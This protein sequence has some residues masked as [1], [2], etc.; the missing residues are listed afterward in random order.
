M[1]S[2]VVALS[3]AF[4]LFHAGKTIKLGM[5]LGPQDVDCCRLEFGGVTH[6]L[7]G[8]TRERNAAL[9]Q[10]QHLWR[11]SV[12][13]TKLSQLLEKCAHRPRSYPQPQSYWFRRRLHFY[14]VERLAP[15]Y[16]RFVHRRWAIFLE[17]FWPQRVLRRKAVFRQRVYGVR[18]RSGPCDLALVSVESMPAGPARSRRWFQGQGNR[19]AFFAAWSSG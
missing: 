3:F 10:Y 16:S 9:V 13:V 11:D 2:F 4:C 8:A 7:F 12:I 6:E 17:S 18:T 5:T 15:R 14:S 19:L 1:R